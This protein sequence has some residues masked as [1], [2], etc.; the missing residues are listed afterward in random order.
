M[1][2][3]VWE[4]W[5]AYHERE[6]LCPEGVRVRSSRWQGWGVKRGF[7]FQA[8]SDILAMIA[9]TFNGGRKAADAETSNEAIDNDKVVLKTGSLD[10]HKAGKLVNGIYIRVSPGVSD[11]QVLT[12]TFPPKRSFGQCGRREGRGYARRTWKEK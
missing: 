1:S 8:R 7:S 12:S 4:V 9:N 6:R 2:E 5:G 3:E 10:Q 11:A